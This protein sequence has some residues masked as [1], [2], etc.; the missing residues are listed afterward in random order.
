MRIVAFSDTHTQHD[1]VKVPHG[2]VLIFAGDFASIGDEVHLFSTWWNYLPHRQKIMV[3]GNHDRLMATVP[4]LA[5][6]TFPGTVILNDSMTEIWGVR[7]WGSPGT[8]CFDALGQAQSFIRPKLWAFQ[9][10]PEEAERRAAAIP[11]EVDVLITHG[12]ST[13]FGVESPIPLV[14]GSRAVINLGDPFLLGAITRVRPSLHIFGHVH[15][16]YGVYSD[17]YTEYKNVAVCDAQYEPVNIPHVIN[18]ETK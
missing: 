7:F 6:E 13:L 17:G 4:G 9:L 11:D 12:P 2:D 10:L 8:M 18:L 14:D 5:R 16:G 15:D 3:F 1:R